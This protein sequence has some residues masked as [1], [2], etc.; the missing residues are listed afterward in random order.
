MS[1]TQANREKVLPA[2]ILVVDDEPFNRQCLKDPLEVVGHHVVEAVDGIDALE[3][4]AEHKPDLILLDVMMPRMDGMSVCQRIKT[5]PSTEHIP[6]IIVTALSEREYRIK[7]IEAG[8]T[9]FLTKPLDLHEVI[10]RVGNALRVGQAY[11]Q[12][13]GNYQELARM[14]Q[15]QENLMDTIVHD[16]RTPINVLHGYLELLADGL[17]KQE[18]AEESREQQ[19]ITTC[20]YHAEVLNLMSSSILNIGQL[21]SEQLP[22]YRD[23]CNIVELGQKAIKPLA[24]IYSERLFRLEVN[25][26]VIEAD[27]D[28]QLISR[29]LGNLLNNARKFVTDGGEICLRISSV[30]DRVEIEVEDSGI[31][32]P[33][34][35]QAEI[36]EKHAQFKTE[37]ARSGSG[38]GLYFCKLAIESH[39]GQISV[40]STVGRGTTF[41]ISLPLHANSTVAASG[42]DDAGAEQTF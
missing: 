40:N 35:D 30:E 9:D 27:C 32:I 24:E 16:M 14:K 25:Q 38:I 11:A 34:A 22:I 5:D 41:T 36:F 12:L 4:I 13:Q 37:K 29:V 17:A 42:A 23:R 3:K 39:D 1:T 18:V 28:A 15:L 8:A 10:L 33:E 7:A 21:E 6:V 26:D 20:M 2:R 19:L 31:G